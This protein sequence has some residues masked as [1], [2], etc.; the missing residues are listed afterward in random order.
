MNI[1]DIDDKIIK[2]A[3]HNYLYEEYVTS[4]QT[5]PLEE[6]L[7]DYKEVVTQFNDVISKN[8]DPDK[9]ILFNRQLKQ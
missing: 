9:Q 8:T 3:R 4:A 7:S 5:K 2:R 6:I 1:T